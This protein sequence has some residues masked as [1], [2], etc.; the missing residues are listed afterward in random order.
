MQKAL[1]GL[2][3]R[4]VQAQRATSSQ[5]D[6][7][8]AREI[9]EQPRSEI[10]PQEQQIG[11]EPNREPAI[12]FADES[13]RGTVSWTEPNA[14]LKTVMEIRFN[15]FYKIAIK[16]QDRQPIRRPKGEISKVLLKVGNEIL[17]EKL[18]VKKRP[19]NKA[20]SALNAAV[21]AVAKAITSLINDQEMEKVGK[22]RQRKIEA[23]K[24]RNTLVSFV[25]ALSNELTRRTRSERGPPSETYLEVAKLHGIS[26]TNDV[27]RL[28]R[29]L[30]DELHIINQE[31]EKNKIAFKRYNERRRGYPAVAREPRVS[32]IQTPVQEIRE[33]WKGI[34]GMPEPFTPSL[35]LMDWAQREGRPSS[36]KCSRLSDETWNDIFS[37]IKPWKATGPDGIQG[38]WWK[39]LPEAKLR[40][41][42]WCETAT[43]NPRKAITRWLCR[44][45]VVLI[46]KGKSGPHGPGDFRP[47]ACL[48]TCYKVLTAMLARQIHECVESRFPMEQVA[49][50]KGIWG[51]THAHILDQSVCKDAQRRNKELHM[52]WVDMTKAFDS[53]SHGAIKW[54]LA[55]L[56]VA[57]RTRALLSTLMSMQTVRYCGYQGQKLV[58]SVPLEIRKGI[59]QGDTLSPLL[60]C[61]AIMPISDWLRTHVAPYQT[62]TASGRGAMGPMRLGHIFYMD[63]LKVY[64]KTFADLVKA[65]EGIQKIANQIGL[66]MNPTKCAMKSLNSE[67]TG[68][69]GMDD[70]PLLGA[71]S[72]YKYLGA[73]QNLLTSF[74]QLWQRVEKQAFA[75]ASRI[76]SSDLVVRQKI[77]GY[78]QVVVPKLKYAMS[79]IIFGTGMMCVM[80]KRA[81]AFDARIRKLLEQTKMRFGHSCTAR[82]YVSKEEG[83]LGLKTVE[84]EMEHT[85]V[86]TWCYLSSKP[87][88]K[89]PYILAE[90]LR[91]SNKRSIATDFNAVLTDNRLERQVTRIDSDKIR[92]KDIIY[93]GARASA[94]A[95]STLIHER[96]VQVHKAQWYEREVASRVL[97][98]NQ[99]NN[100]PF[101]SHSDSFLWSNKGW[102]SAVVLR[103]IWG[104]QEASL[105]TKASA[106]G[107]SLWS[108][109]DHQCRMHCQAKETAEHIVTACSHWRTNIMVERHDEVA[110]V[111][112]ASLKKKYKLRSVITNTREPHVLESEDVVIHWNEPIH[113]S[114]VL[115]HNRPD[116]VVRDKKNN[117]IWIIE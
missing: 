58:K 27:Q 47:I 50:R 54:I 4:R 52:L 68:R 63:D 45:R 18:N 107:V 25:S 20:I 80:R 101:V 90:S 99:Q 46:P 48:N 69:G 30:K 12:R 106:S 59:M 22:N 15:H 79:C 114:G 78:N 87:E 42:Q 92:V 82:L 88:F 103:N 104:A 97:G 70:I 40:L 117:V 62:A 5:S 28:L 11:H 49:M 111:L 89:V 2:A 100:Y 91:T 96:W 34:V 53:V 86:Y 74:E 26:S 81:K 13:R 21:Y 57:Y 64:T 38:Y 66:R 73:E 37:R 95:I 43:N 39:H 16:S 55:K 8:A 44:G 36:E 56:G 84:E 33:Y 17:K 116:I 3:P 14:E 112:Y 109:S 61:I 71:S 1:R 41:R 6:A 51:C 60:F 85:I 10:A 102:V 72:L 65:K 19:R 31:I 32:N 83:G 76:M 7:I 105:L 29:K 67:N 113:T 108:Q 115:K 93:R 24:H 110:K 35:E 98:V 77:N 75:S 9:E 23:E 94:R